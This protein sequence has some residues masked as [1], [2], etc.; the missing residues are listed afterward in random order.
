VVPLISA[1]GLRCDLSRLRAGAS[2]AVSSVP[3]KGMVD[4]LTKSRGWTPFSKPAPCMG[5]PN[6]VVTAVVAL[7]WLV[8]F[9][10]LTPHLPLDQV[11]PRG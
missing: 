10:W 8:I 5:E 9:P 3:R 1:C 4:F 11:M 6:T 2:V 7:L